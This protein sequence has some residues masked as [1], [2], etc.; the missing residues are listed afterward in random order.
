MTP[1]LPLLQDGAFLVDNSFL[2]S[3]TTCVRKAQY[4]Y[5][6]NRSPGGEKAALN[7]GTAIHLALD[8][9]YKTCQNRQVTDADEQHI[10]DNILVP[11]FEQNPVAE[12]EHRT[13]NWCFEI[14]KHYNKN[15]LIEPFKLLKWKDRDE[16]MSEITFIHDL[17]TLKYDGQ[18]IPVKY[19]GRIDLPVVWDDCLMILDHKTTS[20]LGNFYFD[21]QKISPQYEGYCWAMQRTLGTNL[22]SG[23]C[24]NG[25]RTKEAPAKPRSGWDVWWSECFERHKEYL[26]P[27]Q[28][29]EWQEN[30]IA[31]IEEWLWHYG[32]GIFPAKKK[33][34][35]MYGKCAYYDVCYLPK[36]N[37]ELV[38]AGDQFIED[39]WSPLKDVSK[40]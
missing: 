33:A 39:K 32:R 25:I 37:R 13:L 38:L 29:E 14:I 28:L 26:R 16:V 27:G 40:T 24:I 15:Y 5:L 31:L 35:T 1:I 12:G 21:G 4:R 3:T 36:Q 34:C 18:D 17:A 10:H 30:T 2:D 9:R 22:V 20:M 8:W 19:V 6:L 7:F 23:F 11:F